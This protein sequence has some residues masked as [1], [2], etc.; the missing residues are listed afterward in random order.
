MFDVDAFLELLD[1]IERRKKRRAATNFQQ[2]DLDSLAARKMRQKPG[3]KPKRRAGNGTPYTGG[4]PR[5]GFMPVAMAFEDEWRKRR[6]SGGGAG[7]SATGRARP[8]GKTKPESGSTIGGAKAG[9]G[10]RIA[11]PAERL[12]V[13]AGSQPAVVKLVSYAA[14][15]TR[16][17]KL[18]TYQKIGRAHV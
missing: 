3:P 10:I 16:V 6:S 4:K 15:S 1:D 13:A 7:V 18:L 5:T 17:G 14:G 9:S 11:G 12:A 2:Q 8:L